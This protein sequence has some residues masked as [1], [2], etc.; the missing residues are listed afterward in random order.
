MARKIRV[1][2]SHEEPVVEA[3]LKQA[4]QACEDFEA[5]VI[6]DGSVCAPSSFESIDVLLTDCARGIKLARMAS[7]KLRTIVISHDDRES[8]IQSVMKAGARGYLLLNATLDSII[9]AVHCVIDGGSAIDPHIA[10]KMLEGLHHEQLTRRELDVVRLL[11]QGRSNKCIA[12]ELDISVGT[13]KTHVKSILAK[14]NA[15]S[16]MHA[17]AVAQRRGLI[18]GLP[19]V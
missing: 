17:V 9:H 12:R 1:L 4:I 11:M 16:R 10:T 7:S 2:I 15:R 8:S 14:L 18:S 5:S 19:A 6:S 13:A 3:G